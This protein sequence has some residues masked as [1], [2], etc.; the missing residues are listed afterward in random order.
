MSPLTHTEIATLWSLLVRYRHELQ[1]E[2]M[3]YI[4][5]T[6]EECKELEDKIEKLTEV[7]DFTLED[8]IFRAEQ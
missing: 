6:D 3:R 7:I 2:D 8:A 4:N 5:E 1:D